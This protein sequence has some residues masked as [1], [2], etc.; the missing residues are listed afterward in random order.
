MAVFELSIR[1]RQDGFI[2]ELQ[3]HA[4]ARVL[5]LYGPS[6]S[7]KTTT[8]EVMAGLRTPDEGRVVVDGHCFFDSA[9][10]I[11]EGARMRAVGY[12]PQDV[13]LFPH[14]D[15]RANVEYGWR[16]DAGVRERLG[17]LLELDALQS[18]QVSSLSGGE[19]QRVALA[20]ALATSP[21]LLLLDEPLAAV[22][23]ARRRRIIEALERVRDELVTPIVYVTHALEEVRQLADV[24]IVLD[25]GR[26]VASGPPSDVLL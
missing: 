11:N 7:G 19:R 26:V 6:G 10:R 23:L 17:R 18:R 3:A 4:E 14:M 20:R 2:L 8:L 16:G 13:L 21:R 22:D 12:V 25:G 1:L 24:V 5:A 15:V 9:R